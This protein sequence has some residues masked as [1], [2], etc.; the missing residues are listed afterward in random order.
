MRKKAGWHWLY[1]YIFALFIYPTLVFAVLLP[2][3]LS[4]DQH[5]KVI[6]YDP[7]NVVRVLARYGYQ[8][9]IEFSPGEAV[10][11]VSSG[12]SLS[13]LVDH[14]GHYLFIKPV[15]ASKTNLSVITN[16]HVYHFELDS[17]RQKVSPTYILRFVY[18]KGG[19]D[20]SGSA[21]AVGNFDP[22]QLNWKYSFTGHR[23]LA[24]K[25]AFDNGQFTYFKFKNG[26]RGRLPAI[27]LVDQDQQETL[28]NHHMQGHY[29]VV[30][31]VAEQFTLRDGKLVTS[32]YNDE[33]I[34][35]WE[36]IQ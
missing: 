9:Q 12:D 2:K 26:G 34:G 7:N 36:Q 6:P 21:N 3:P 13:W 14:D 33:A 11:T 24:S 16:A 10:R 18:P 31:S 8:T 28:I 5:V 19:F 20:G 4:S 30:N 29:V 15:A 23:A 25:E 32:V 22:T 17:T 35:D 27:F 1:L